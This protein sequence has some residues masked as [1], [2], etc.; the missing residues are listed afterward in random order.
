METLADGTDKARLPGWQREMT[1]L[2]RD[3]M[4]VFRFGR[5]TQVGHGPTGS[6]RWRSVAQL[7]LEPALCQDRHCERMPLTSGCWIGTLGESQVGGV[8]EQRVS[9]T[10]RSVDGFNGLYGPCLRDDVQVANGLSRLVAAGHVV[11]AKGSLHPYLPFD[12]ALRVVGRCFKNL[13]HVG[14]YV[15]IHRS[16]TQASMWALTRCYIQF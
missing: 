15:R 7:G 6:Q 11:P 5:P 12:A 10:G 16:L 4:K 2:L 14:S 8:G 9:E 3:L 1:V 13:P